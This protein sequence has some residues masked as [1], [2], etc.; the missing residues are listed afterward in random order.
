MYFA[1]YFAQSRTEGLRGRRPSY[2][3]QF[4]YAA[5]R[6]GL[7][8]RSTR[9]RDELQPE[10]GF[11]R[12]ENFRR[13]VVQARFSPRTTNNPLVRKMDL[14][15]Q[16]RIH[17]R[18]RQPPGVARAAAARSRR[19]STT[20][21]RFVAVLRLYEFLPAPFLHLDRRA[22]IPAAATRSTTRETGVR[23][24]EQQ[25]RV[26]GTSAFEIGSFYGGH[27]KT[28]TFSGRVEMHAAARRRAEHLVQLGRPAEGR[29][30]TTIFGGRATFTMTPQM[31]VAALVQYT[32]SNTSLLDQR[33]VPLGVSAGQ[34]AVRG[35]HRRPTTLPPRGTDLQ[36]RGSSSK[37]NRLFRF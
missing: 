34:R 36:N 26:S 23:R 29:F 9:R 4:N 20:A 12:R 37:I 24:P 25:H 13:N 35:L 15:G 31:F 17:H 16:L 1:G 30:T 7:A 5:D 21:T 32:S 14:P 27:K 10:V 22:R 2:R 11:L 19:N 6:Y 8:A 18:Q 3:A 33:Q 28:A